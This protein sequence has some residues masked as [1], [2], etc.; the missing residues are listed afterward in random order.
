MIS[1][2]KDNYQ[3]HPSLEVL[4]EC[5][6]DPSAFDTLIGRCI[7]IGGT[8]NE[9]IAIRGMS[10]TK[11]YFIVSSPHEVDAYFS[12]FKYGELKATL[13]K[14]S[15]TAASLLSEVANAWPKISPIHRSDFLIELKVWL[16]TLGMDSTDE[17]LG[18]LTG[19]SRSVITNL[20]R[21]QRLSPS[22]RSMASLNAISLAKARTLAS[23][24][25]SDQNRLAK[26]CI[27]RNL[28][29]RELY[30]LAFP[31]RLKGV[32]KGVDKSPDIKHF[33]RVISERS[34][35]DI[36]YFPMSDNTSGTLDINFSTIGELK[37]ILD[38]VI[39]VSQS[40]EQSGRLSLEIE[41]MDQIDALFR[42]MITE[43]ID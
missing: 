32:S 31:Q 21:L 41:R 30:K 35:L 23:L 4:R 37:R 13:L 33:E 2:T 38:L 22:V 20:L 16:K 40:N 27:D 8:P 39:T 12:G 19:V 24:N 42:K 9:V 25:S 17:L 6:Y 1:L 34:G 36:S 28:S 43:G 29:Y 18:R 11:D 10:N 7:D 26:I 3:W 14:S 15:H 5:G